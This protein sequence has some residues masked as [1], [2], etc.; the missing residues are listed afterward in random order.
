MSL[1]STKYFIKSISLIFFG[2]IEHPSYSQLSSLYLSV[3]V[4]FEKK[5]WDSKNPNSR[6]HLL[7]CI[8]IDELI[9]KNCDL[10]NLNPAAHTTIWI[11]FPNCVA[12][13]AQPPEYNFSVIST[14][15]EVANL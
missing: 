6:Y 8:T 7:S 12:Y 11:Y 2:P 1:Y 10:D 5:Q 15:L 13:E 3:K 9:N 14:E 4:L